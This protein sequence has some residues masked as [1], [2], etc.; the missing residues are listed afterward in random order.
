MGNTRNPG[1]HNLAVLPE[2]VADGITRKGQLGWKG[3]EELHPCSSRSPWQ[4]LFCRRTGG[5]RRL[6]QSL[7]RCHC[8]GGSSV[9]AGVAQGAPSPA[10]PSCVTKAPRLECQQHL[11]TN[12]AAAL[13]ASHTQT[14]Q[15][16]FGT[17][18]PWGQ[19]DAG[20]KQPS[21]EH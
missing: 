21:Q 4:R 3:M 7:A 10:Q 6:L 8:W 13:P 11:V 2:L 16:R 5:K 1:N 15:N 17:G 18:M 9:T 19:E 20:S 12:V 14:P